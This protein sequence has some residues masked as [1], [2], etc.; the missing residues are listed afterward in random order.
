MQNAA[1]T[2]QVSGGGAGKA[3]G[4]LGHVGARARWARIP[5]RPSP[6][7]E[8][9]CTPCV[10]P[11][12]P[13]HAR[14][15]PH[16]AIFRRPGR[17][18]RCS[19]KWR[20]PRSCFAGKLRTRAGAYGDA[21]A[22]AGGGPCPAPGPEKFQGRACKTACPLVC[23]KISPIRMRRFCRGRIV[24]HPPRPAGRRRSRRRWG[25]QGTASHLR[26]LYHPGGHERPH[27]GCLGCRCGA[28]EHI[29]GRDYELLEPV[30]PA[31]EG[32]RNGRS[33]RVQLP[34]REPHYAAV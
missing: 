21:A 2:G 3:A 22:H 32:C 1:E 10:R 24:R 11:H 16:G 5:C 15:F 23:E 6:G 25:S 17:A 14:N 8:K 28:V 7:A 9:F 20:Y 31:Q 13:I 34:G 26:P 18:G 4:T 29:A 30:V 27:R 19:Q 33:D 12:A